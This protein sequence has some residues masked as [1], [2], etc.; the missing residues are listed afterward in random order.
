MGSLGS[1]GAIGSGG[2]VDASVGSVAGSVSSW[3]GVVGGGVV[4]A[5]MVGASLAEGSVG[6]VG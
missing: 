5:G 4:T 2:I 3:V 6:E 1:S